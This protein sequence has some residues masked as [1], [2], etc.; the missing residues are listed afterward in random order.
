MFSIK[1]VSKERKKE[2]KII[3]IRHKDEKLPHGKIN[4]SGMRMIYIS[5]L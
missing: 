3:K 5:S 2:K 4:T 1:E